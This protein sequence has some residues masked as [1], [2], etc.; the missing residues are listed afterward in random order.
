MIYKEAEEEKMELVEQTQNQENPIQENLSTKGGLKTLPFI[1]VNEAFEKVASYG[2]QPNLIL[3][4]INEYHYSSA[5]V[6]FIKFLGHFWGFSFRF[7]LGKIQSFCFGIMYETSILQG[8]VQLWLT[9]MFPQMKPKPCDLSLNVCDSATPAQFVFLLSSLGLMSIGAGCIRP[10]DPAKNEE[11][12]QTY[13]NFYYA[14]IGIS[15]LLALTVI[16]YIQDHMGW[17]VGFAVPAMLMFL[18]ALFFF[19]GNSF[20]IKVKA[21]TSLFTGFAKV[22]V[23][24]WRNRH[25]DL[26]LAPQTINS[27]EVYYYSTDLKLVAPL[28][29]LRFLNKACI[30]RDPEED[31]KPDGSPTKPWELCTV[32]QV[33]TL[34]SLIRVIPIWSTGFM[35]YMTLS[36]NS[37]PVLQAKTMNRHITTNFEIPAGSFA[38]FTITTLTIWVAFY[39][40]VIVPILAKYT[41]KP[42][43]ISATIRMGIGLLLSCIAMAVA[44]I[45]ERIR[46]RNS[47]EENFSIS[48]LWLVPQFC[49]IGLAE[50]FNAIRQIEFYY[51]QFPKSMSSIAVGFFTLGT[52]FSGLLGGL[53]ISV[54][55]KVTKSSDSKESW[56]SSNPNL[57]HYD[58]YYWFLT[59][60]SVVNLFY[61]V[62]CCWCY[63][64]CGE[65]ENTRASDDGA[66]V[67][68]GMLENS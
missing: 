53:I 27:D 34:K 40:R 24:A 19:L 18:S 22:F 2:I 31:L 28:N 36:Q 43:G 16:V 49:L 3:Y 21:S 17:K 64:P 62:I 11:I 38:L 10:Y 12:L 63:R 7:I 58:Y 39:D 52:A 1:I 47:V 65:E 6:S 4:L 54:V 14:T 66:E 51:R 59:F 8:I 23:A 42:Y 26:A 9:A 20:Y 44:G 57:G 32:S 56:V 25:L 45:V 60:L 67:N 35:I 13:F 41:G 15:T 55:D 50:A 5:T 30:I 46:R 29:N 48:A 61:F 33:E 68:E 37:I